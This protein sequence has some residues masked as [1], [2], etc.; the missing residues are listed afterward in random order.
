M[1]RDRLTSTHHT[2]RE[3]RQNMIIQFRIGSAPIINLTTLSC[4]PTRTSA[5]VSFGLLLALS[6]SNQTRRRKERREGRKGDVDP[7]WLWGSNDVIRALVLVL[8]KG[9]EEGREAQNWS[10]PPFSSLSIVQDCT[11]LTSRLAYYFLARKLV[12]ASCSILSYLETNYVLPHPKS[13]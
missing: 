13:T 11:N 9:D 5:S 10:T 4:S 3:G 7:F 12:R 2:L 8:R 1:S 6:D